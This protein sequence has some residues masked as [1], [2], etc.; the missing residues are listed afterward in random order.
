MLHQHFAADT[1]R[2]QLVGQL[3]MHEH[4]AVQYEQKSQQRLIENMEESTIKTLTDNYA[5][6]T[7]V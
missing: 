7:E 4:G 2:K 5:R 6:L 1:R 3:I